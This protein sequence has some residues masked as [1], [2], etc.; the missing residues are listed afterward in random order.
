MFELGVQAANNGIPSEEDGYENNHL[1]H[2]RELGLSKF[3]G[4]WND[5]A[6][7]VRDSDDSGQRNRYPR[8]RSERIIFHSENG[9]TLMNKEELAEMFV[10]PVEE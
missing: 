1:T 7:D 8:L 2:A 6:H 4:R 3:T 5:D 10:E 9:V